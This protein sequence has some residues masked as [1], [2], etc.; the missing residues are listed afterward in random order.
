[1]KQRHYLI[2]IIIV[3]I[4][5]AAAYYLFHRRSTTALTPTPTGVS[6]E[7]PFSE[8]QVTQHKKLWEGYIKTRSE[9]AEKLQSVDRTAKS[10]SYSAYRALKVAETYAYNG[11]ILHRLYF[12][13][14]TTA[15]TTPS[16]EIRTLLERSF[17]SFDAFKTDFMA[18]GQSAR[19]WVMTAY[20]LD[21][22]KVYNFLLEEHNQTVPV[23]TMP[24]LILDVYE[25]AYMI[26]FGID[27]TTYLNLFWEHINW[28]VVEQRYQ[29]LFKPFITS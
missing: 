19:G 18:C 3:A 12:E 26:E 10:R 20:S 8:K 14:L 13:N 11:D 6:N 16:E 15:T 21:D 28:S 29:A 17:G 4:L 1:M 9:I 27:R 25:H 22:H 7:T 23:M 2:S 24:L 5:A